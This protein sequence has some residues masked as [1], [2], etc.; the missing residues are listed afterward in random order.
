MLC[1]LAILLTQHASNGSPLFFFFFFFWFKE[2][3]ACSS[4]MQSVLAYRAKAAMN[5][6]SR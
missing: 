6:G 1:Y 2:L 4:D 3:E 5:S